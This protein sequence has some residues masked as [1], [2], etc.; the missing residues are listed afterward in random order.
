M[1]YLQTGGY[2]MKISE[3]FNLEKNQR[4]LDFIDID[5][6]K[7]IPL[8][9]DPYYISTR[10]DSWAF[11]AQRTIKSFFQHIID[12][13]MSD[14]KDRA[15]QLFMH[16][17]EPN[18]TCLGVST[19]NP[20]GR[21]VG[22]E[23]AARIFDYIIESRA[24]EYG[25]VGNVED[26]VLFVDG[27]HKD[28]ISDLTT[29]LIRKHLV[30]YTQNQCLLHN[31]PL[32]SDVP[33]G[34]YWDSVRNDWNNELAEML[35]INER[36]ILLVPK[37][38]VSFSF[39][40]TPETYC[41]H[42]VLNFKQNEYLRLGHLV[43]RKTLKDGTER[44]MVY[45]KD[46]IEAESPFRK[47]YL[48]DFTRNHPQILDDF[49]S[50][51]KRRMSPL[52]DEELEGE[53]TFNLDEFIEYLI[54]KLNRIDAGGEQASAYHKLMTGIIE[55]LFYP[56]IVCPVK[57]QEIHQGRKRIDI[58]FDNAAENGFFFELHNAKQ[59]P[60]RYIFFECKNYSKEVA[61]PELDQMSGR[62]SPNRGKFGVILC[63]SIDNMDRFIQR[64]TDTHN[65]DRGTIIPLVDDDIERLLRLRKVEN[66]HEINN[67]LRE[68]L[69]RVILR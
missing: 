21:G 8:F 30:E 25:I 2:V 67:F 39:Q 19:A 41:Q 64:C 57:E 61:N 55:L 63:R 46:I 7:D 32:T 33:T 62:F 66:F 10:N 65:D 44:R 59:I 56:D 53:A 15:R 51:V 3:I 16:L 42:F 34:E 40:Y 9:L 28:K 29:N 50:Q 17:S 4:E 38:V 5:I 68:R 49:K 18:E 20:Q 12:L 26:F 14:R 69:R 37:G 23:E 1:G 22:P 52:K 11:A 13:Y 47:E 54:E 27:I 35:I 24:I 48:R 6:T 45:K 60:S 43:T 58:S 36:R 31:I